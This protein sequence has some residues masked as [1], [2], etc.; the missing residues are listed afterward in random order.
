MRRAVALLLLLASCGGEDDASD[1]T[2]PGGVADAA[3]IADSAPAGPDASLDPM[4]LAETGLYSD[5]ASE[6]LAPG[7]IQYEVNYELWAD[8]AAKR[9]FVFLPPGATIDT[10]DMNFWRLPQGTKLWKE[11]TR[12]GVRVETR[13]IWK[14]GPTDE[15]WF[16]MSYAWNEAG[17]QAPA[18]EFGVV[19]ALGTEQNIPRATDCQTCHKRQ[20][21]FALGFGAL[22]L[23]HDR[24]EMNLPALIQQGRLSDP[25]ASSTAPVFPLPG[26]P[27]DQ[28]ALGYL[29]GNC[30]VCH[31]PYSDVQDLTTLVWHLDVASLATVGET[32]IFTNAVGVPPQIMLFVNPPL[33]SVIE[34]GSPEG[35]AAFFRMSQRDP[36]QDSQVPMPPLATEK[37]D[38]D[39][40]VA[41]LRAWIESLA[42]Q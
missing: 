20:P 21:G 32:T 35:S 19:N 29:H 30:G 5:L 36:L 31:N 9:R 17:T 34:P 1:G 15:D 37:V 38:E 39:G 41:A 2:S 40:G 33:T 6:T 23:D 22:Q 28:A 7:V 3:P 12:D 25:P 18:A 16:V 24:G 14:Q 4:S 8:G 11:F 42:P 27:V 26:D 13:L 10:T